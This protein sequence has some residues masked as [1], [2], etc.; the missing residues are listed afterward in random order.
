MILRKL[1]IAA[2][3]VVSVPAAATEIKNFN[4]GELSV[5]GLALFGNGF[6]TAGT[7]QD[8]Y[9][10]EIDRTASADGVILTLDPSPTD[11]LGIRIASVL[12]S[13][14]LISPNSW[15]LYDFGTLTAGSYTLSIVTE[16]LSHSSGLS[17]GFLGSSVTKL[18]KKQLLKKP[19]VGYGGLL[20]L[21][22]SNSTRV[23]EPSTL[24]LLGLGLI[25]VSL[26]ARRRRRTR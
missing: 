22:K 26:A 17:L 16:V 5:P 18:L 10:F 8:N 23:P 11:S 14:N 7:Y 6:T 19:I 3:L 21:T 25:S 20:S 4:L 13:G 15:G 12:L 1:V 24:A 9:S 2:L